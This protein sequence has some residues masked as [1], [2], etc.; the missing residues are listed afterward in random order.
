MWG[1]ERWRE[2]VVE[3]EGRRVGGGR[4]VTV[5]WRTRPGKTQTTPAGGQAV[6]PRYHCGAVTA[7]P[8]PAC[9]GSVLQLWELLRLHACFAHPGG[10][11]WPSPLSRKPQAQQCQVRWPRLEGQVALGGGRECRVRAGS[12]R[13]LAGAGGPGHGGPRLPGVPALGGA[14]A[15]EGGPRAQLEALLAPTRT[16]ITRVYLSK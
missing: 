14:P 5:G 2:G 11:A 3:M 8:P 15:T 1:P 4:D 6:S 12:G 9:P 16:A 7:G 10:T 13:G